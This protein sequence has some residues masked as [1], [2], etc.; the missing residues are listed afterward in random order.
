[1]Y[2]IFVSLVII[3]F[4]ISFLLFLS[5]FPDTSSKGKTIEQINRARH[6][7]NV[8][9]KNFPFFSETGFLLYSGPFLYFILYII[10]SSKIY[11]TNSKSIFPFISVAF[12]AII[13]FGYLFI[14]TKEE[15]NKIDD[16]M[17]SLN[18]FIFIQI[19]V[20]IYSISVLS[21]STIVHYLN[22]AL[23][24]YK[25]DEIIVTIVKKD[26]SV[27]RSSRGR[28]TTHFYFYIK[29]EVEGMSSISVSDS[30]YRKSGT[31]DKLKLYLKKGI[32]GLPYINGDMT[33]IPKGEFEKANNE[34]NISPE[35]I[36]DLI[37]SLIDNMVEC[38]EGSFIMGNPREGNTHMVTLTKP[39]YI[40]KYEVTQK[41]YLTVMGINPSKNIDENKPVETVNWTSAKS[42]CNTLN[43]YVKSIPDGYRF[44]LPTE[45]QWEYA[46]RAGTTTD[47]NSGK[48]LNVNGYIS[49]NLNELAWYSFNSEKTS[50]PVGLK[51]PN[52]W[53][54]YDMHGNVAE[55]CRD[56]FRYRIERDEIDPLGPSRPPDNFWIGYRVV[57]GG[58][59]ALNAKF[60][61]C[62]SCTSYYRVEYNEN[63]NENFIG[64]RIALVCDDINATDEN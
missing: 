5:I 44:D 3:H 54:I 2:T 56:Y 1:M 60:N 61:S 34:Q 25:A 57:R 8:F 43:K 58:C 33:I 21:G 47:L 17:R 52:A 15:Y 26:W 55:W 20:Y 36:E 35:K 45:A 63:L 28:E 7:E 64:F 4:V 51:K 37:P 23:D 12:F 53:G 40:S 16:E 38:P 62:E 50:H 48:D 31:N 18:P 9:K 14:K 46:C 22:S 11:V 30:L 13:I 29:P 39:F 49:Q 41:E 32:F 19:I 59:Y 27:T 42:F 6:Y 24:F 10:F